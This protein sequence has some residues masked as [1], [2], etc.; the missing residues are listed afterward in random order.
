[1]GK[2]YITACSPVI[3]VSSWMNAAGSGGQGVG[4]PIGESNHFNYPNSPITIAGI[5]TILST[6]MIQVWSSDSWILLSVIFK[7]TLSFSPL[8]AQTYA[9][10]PMCG[11]SP[12]QL[13]DEACGRGSK[14]C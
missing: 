14:V 13:A 6:Y 4:G 9:D 2:R 12:T 10:Y 11:W 8:M 5:S 1:M 3:H 7:L